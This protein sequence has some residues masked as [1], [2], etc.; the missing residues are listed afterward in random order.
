VEAYRVMKLQ[1]TKELARTDLQNKDKLKTKAGYGRNC[2]IRP[3]DCRMKESP[4]QRSQ[5]HVQ[6]SEQTFK[7][8][9][10]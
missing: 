2:E 4:E 7:L 5:L 10:I 3:L 9:L 6:G 1:T 8:N